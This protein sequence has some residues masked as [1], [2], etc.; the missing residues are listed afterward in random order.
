MEVPVREYVAICRD[1]LTA[2]AAVLSCGQMAQHKQVRHILG[3]PC[4][5]PASPIAT[6]CSTQ[7]TGHG[8]IEYENQLCTYQ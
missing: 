6:P 7:G 2:A 5:V 1:A 8:H 3:A 4:T